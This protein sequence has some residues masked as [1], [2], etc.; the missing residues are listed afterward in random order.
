MQPAC[1]VGNDGTWR[2]VLVSD[3]MWRFRT[4]NV[5]LNWP[6]CSGSEEPT[7]YRSRF[8]SRTSFLI[9][10]R[11]SLGSFRL[12]FSPLRMSGRGVNAELSLM[13]FLSFLAFVCHTSHG[14]ILVSEECCAA[15]LVDTFEAAICGTVGKAG[16]AAQQDFCD[17]V[18]AVSE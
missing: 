5:P 11:L 14:G 15:S 7:R 18:S 2:Q 4:A 9:M 1:T 6:S 17:K 10:F 16:Y 13:A 3:V 12:Q 8:N